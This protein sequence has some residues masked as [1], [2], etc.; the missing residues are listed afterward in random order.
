MEEMQSDIRIS[1][2]TFISKNEKKFKEVYQIDKKPMGEGAFGVV[3][4]CR[5]RELGFTRAVKRV[6]K[7][8]IKNMNSFKLEI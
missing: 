6:S 7:K 5:H 2:Q 1:K 8:K 4:K 3:S